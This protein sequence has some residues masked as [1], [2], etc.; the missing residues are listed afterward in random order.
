MTQDFTGEVY[1]K[2]VTRPLEVHVSRDEM[3]SLIRMAVR[4]ES[5]PVFREEVQD[6][7]SPIRDDIIA[8]TKIVERLQKKSEERD[9]HCAREEMVVQTLN[10]RTAAMELTL[11]RG[12][13]CRGCVNRDRI[14]SLET[15]VSG[16]TK[17][18]ES[19]RKVGWGLVSS[20]MILAVKE[21]V[22]HVFFKTA[23]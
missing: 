10:A 6:F 13:Q 17:S 14:L 8:L 4:E 20:L 5:R 21:I 3:L 23:G 15:T 9:I 1:R 16:I 12:D 18:M 22:V 7:L 11:E 19:M 2:L